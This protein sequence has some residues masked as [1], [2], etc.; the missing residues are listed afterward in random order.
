MSDPAPDTDELRQPAHHRLYGRAKGKSLTVHQQGLVDELLPRL[1]IDPASLPK[2]E[3]WM[4]IGFGAAHHLLHQA[5]ENPDV[6]LLGA[7]PFLNGVAKALAAIEAEGITN[8]R[9]HDGDARE[10]LSRLPDGALS[11]LFVLYPDPWP[12]ARHRKRRLIQED[13]IEEFARLL[14]SGAEWRFVSDITDYVDWVLTRVARSPH[15]RWEPAAAHDFLDP[16]PDW[17]VTHFERKAI[18]EGRIPHYFTFTRV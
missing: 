6:T 3:L 10:V 2:G 17:T 4:E 18:R 7:E 12:K 16:P 5:R 15:F 13:T 1:R 11:R 8:I 14:P 9:L